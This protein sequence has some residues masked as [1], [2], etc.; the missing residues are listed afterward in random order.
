MPNGA[1]KILPMYIERNSKELRKIGL[2]IGKN[3]QEGK[4][5]KCCE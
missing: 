5:K 1:G 3:G 4:A 2:G